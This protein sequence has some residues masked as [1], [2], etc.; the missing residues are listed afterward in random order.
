MGGSLFYAKCDCKFHSCVCPQPEK[1]EVTE[2]RNKKEKKKSFFYLGNLEVKKAKQRKRSLR[3]TSPEKTTYARNLFWRLCW[4]ISFL[5]YVSFAVGKKR[6]KGR[7]LIFQPLPTSRKQELLYFLF[8]GNY[9][10]PT[11]YLVRCFFF[12][13]VWKICV[14][15]FVLKVCEQG[16]VR[17]SPAIYKAGRQRG[18]RPPP[19]MGIPRS[20]LQSPWQSPGALLGRTVPH[21]WNPLEESK[22]APLFASNS[23]WACLLDTQCGRR[24]GVGSKGN[25][26]PR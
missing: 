15:S 17:F 18:R 5:G 8:P 20:R 1:T 25:Q 21:S 7:G 2:K 26:T 22:E 9:L 10:A 23:L 14:L 13:F 4:T 16:R 12:F 11:H 6:K 19:K 24:R 3:E